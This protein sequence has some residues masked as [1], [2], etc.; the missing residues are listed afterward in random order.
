MVSERP[1]RFDFELR[2]NAS[3]KISW[4]AVALPAADSLKLGATWQPGKHHLAGEPSCVSAVG[5]PSCVSN[6]VSVLPGVAIDHPP[7]AGFFLRFLGKE[8]SLGEVGLI[9]LKR[10]LHL[11]QLVIGQRKA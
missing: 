2:P 9:G 11:A 8:N 6:R 10:D 3:V 5:E 4:A 7:A 1:A